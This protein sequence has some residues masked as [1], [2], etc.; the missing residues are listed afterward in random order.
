[1]Y[2]DDNMIAIIGK[3]CGFSEFQTK[4]FSNMYRNDIFELMIMKIFNYYAYVNGEE[5]TK[6][7]E[8]L[9][10]RIVT[11]GN[12]ED[13]K[14]LTELFE[15]TLIS[16]PE[17]TEQIK[18]MFAKIQTDMFFSFMNETNEEGKLEMITY[19]LQQKKRI[20]EM[21]SDIKEYDHRQEALGDT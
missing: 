7:V 8:K 19:M 15:Q 6:E 17:L 18:D 1:M 3:Y 11:K 16:Y 12:V 10:H 5:G 2:F 20:Q 14:K 4:Q 13:Q 21:G 9:M